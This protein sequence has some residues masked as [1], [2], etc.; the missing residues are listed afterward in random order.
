MQLVIFVI[1]C[2]QNNFYYLL[3]FFFFFFEAFFRSLLLV[4][5]LLLLVSSILFC[6]LTISFASSLFL[7]YYFAI[8]F[9]LILTS[10]IGTH[11]YVAHNS[12]RCERNKEFFYKEQTM[13]L[14]CRLRLYTT[15]IGPVYLLFSFSFPKASKSAPFSF[16]FSKSFQSSRLPNLFKKTPQ[17]TSKPMKQN[18]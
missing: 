17:N 4:S 11:I 3:F 15:F 5:F 2:L 10:V 9:L 8:S 16:P 7:T 13:S 12:D 14:A 1:Y 6:S 18:V